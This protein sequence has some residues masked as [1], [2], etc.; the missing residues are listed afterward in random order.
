MDRGSAIHKL[1]ERIVKDKPRSKIPEELSCFTEEIRALQKNKTVRVE[2]Q[3][4][5]TNKWGFTDWFGESAW[6]RVVIDLLYIEKGMLYVVDWKTGKLNDSHSGQLSLYA[7]AGLLL[8]P[9]LDEV[10]VQL[11][12]AD[13][14]IIMPEEVKIYTQADVPALKKEWAAKAKPILADRRFPPKPGNACQ[15][16]HFSKAKGGQCD[17]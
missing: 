15:W 4:A 3:Q 17:F 12:Y 11:F 1:A 10:N 13:H 2:V 6:C 7:L 5:F 9:D 14:G 16:C 8:Y